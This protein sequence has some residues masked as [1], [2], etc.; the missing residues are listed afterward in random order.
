MDLNFLSQAD[1]ITL[2]LELAKRALESAKTELEQ[3]KQAYD[4]MLAQADAHGI[5]KAK[6][7]KLT[8]DRVQALIESGILSAKQRGE[9]PIH[10]ASEPKRERTR[11]VAKKDVSELA[12]TEDRTGSGTEDQQ[13]EHYIDASV[14]PSVELSNSSISNT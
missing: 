4:E 1:N 12:R 7:K 11:K 8:E 14:E 3:T 9:N 5:P 13:E 10:G 2:K 6:L